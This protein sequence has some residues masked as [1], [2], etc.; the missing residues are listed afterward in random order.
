MNIKFKISNDLENR[1]FDQVVSS[2]IPDCSRNKAS[3]LISNGE[4]VINKMTRKSSYKVKAGDVIEG[5]SPKKEADEFIPTPESLDLE[6]MFED[7]HIL[8]I[9]K[10]AG[11]VVHPAPGHSS[12]TLVNALLN[13]I[14]GLITVGNDKSRAGIV[15]RLDKDTS[16]AIVIAKSDFAFKFLQKEFKYRRVEKR[17]LA[18][19]SG[20][21]EPNKGE[22]VLPIG[23]HPVRR[24]LMCINEENGKYARTGWNVIKKFGNSCLVE[25]RLFTGRTH[26]IRVHFYAMG[27]PLIGDRVYQYRRN[28]KKQGIVSRQMLHSSLISFRHPYSGRRLTFNAAIPDDFVQTQ[29]KIESM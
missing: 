6:I 8:L 25:A 2:I 20:I 23:R 18:L 17:Y 12:G 28:R 15:H 19:I 1:R 16:G 24:K 26:Q 5:I 10:P 21:I 4:F 11:M 13:H 14:P 7:D 3:F 27:H 9:N 22:I 29:N